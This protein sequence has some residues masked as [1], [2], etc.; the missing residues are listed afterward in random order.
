MY[1]F[2]FDSSS[3]LDACFE[4]IEHIE[5]RWG[6]ESQT[7]LLTISCKL[8]RVMCTW[9]TSTLE[10][11]S[12][13]LNVWD[14]QRL[15]N[16]TLSQEMSLKNKQNIGYNFSFKIGTWLH[17]FSNIGTTLTR[18]LDT[19][20]NKM[21]LVLTIFACLNFA[22]LILT[23]HSSKFYLNVIFRLLNIYFNFNLP[24]L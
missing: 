20:L 23:W 24:K 15:Y 9:N 7:K 4:T 10:A 12:G 16:K 5:F 8:C 17:N 19:L 11:E 1:I 3:L 18:R 22:F 14:Q 13:K 6:N 2:T 21:L